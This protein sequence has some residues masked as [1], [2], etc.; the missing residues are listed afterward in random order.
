VTSFSYPATF[1]L[2]LFCG[3]AQ[4]QIKR[5]VTNEEIAAWADEYMAHAEKFDHFS[6]VILIARDGVPFFNKSYGMA[7]IELSVPNSSKTKFRIGSVSKQ[8]TATAI[9]QLQERGL[10]NVNDSIVNHLK[11]CPVSWKEITIRHLLNHT[12]GL[13]SFTQLPAASGQF[14]LLPHTHDEVVNL[15]RDLPLESKPGEKFNYNNSGYYLLGMIIEKASKMKYADYLQ[16]NLLKPLDLKN[17]GFDD[18]RTILENRASSYYLNKN[19][20]VRNSYYTDME[21]L[22][23]IGGLYSTMEDLLRWEQS[24]VKATLL[25]PSTIKEMMTPHSGGFG[26]GW[27]VDQLGTLTRYRHDGGIT[28][29]SASLQ[30]L[31]SERLTVIAISNKGEDG[32]IRAACDIAGRVCGVPATIRGIQRELMTLRSDQL[33]A[34]VTHTRKHF[35]RFDFQEEKVEELADYLVQKNEK[36]QAIEVLDVNVKCHPTSARACIRLALAYESHGN[37]EQALQYFKQALKLEPNHTKAKE[38]VERLERR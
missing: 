19:K 10:L 38:Y 33:Q 8:F 5:A 34:I 26:Y 37:K 15:F 23:S 3:T 13:V 2:L 7:N 35:P 31:P 20:V 27:Q 9:L 17:T 36:A 32:G 16:E 29:F 12:S 6:G 14:L 1:V 21:T 18:Q 25:K 4:A 24:F 11:N 30:T 22:F 28:N